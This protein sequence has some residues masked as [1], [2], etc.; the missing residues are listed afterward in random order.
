MGFERLVMFLTKAEK[1]HDV[2]PFPV[3]Y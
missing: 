1:I 3:S 2:I